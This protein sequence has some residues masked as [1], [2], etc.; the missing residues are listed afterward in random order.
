MHYFPDV[1]N[2]IWIGGQGTN[3][4]DGSAIDPNAVPNTSLDNEEE[5]LLMG[6]NKW[7]IADWL[8]SMQLR[9]L[10]ASQLEA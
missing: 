10:C 6:C 1:N 5:L 4:L 2:Y 9:I 3:W 8:G 7:T